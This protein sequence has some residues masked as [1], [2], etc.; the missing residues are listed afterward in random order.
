MNS[1]QAF[2]TILLWA[3]IAHQNVL[4][5]SCLDNSLAILFWTQFCF[6]ILCNKLKLVNFFVVTLNICRKV[7]KKLSL[8]VQCL[9]ATISRA[10]DLL[11][12]FYFIDNVVMKARLAEI[13]FVLTITHVDL[14]KFFLCWISNITFTY[15]A[16]LFLINFFENTFETAFHHIS[17]LWFWSFLLPLWNLSSCSNSR[18]KKLRNPLPIPRINRERWTGMCLI[19]IILWMNTPNR[20]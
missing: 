14:L 16:L 8:H 4:G 5:S 19:P 20:R 2:T 6:R 11:K 10:V 7:L 12:I 3:L 13:E 1:Q 15:L 17:Y 18:K 9:R